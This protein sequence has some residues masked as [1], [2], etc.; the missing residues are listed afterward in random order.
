MSK[1]LIS[2]GSDAT[3]ELAWI[4]GSQYEKAIFLVYLFQLKRKYAP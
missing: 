3:L 4:H 1:D 2:W